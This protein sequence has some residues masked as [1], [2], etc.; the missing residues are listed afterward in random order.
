MYYQVKYFIIEHIYNGDKSM[1]SKDQLSE[2]ILHDY[3]SFNS[4]RAKSDEEIDLTEMDFSNATLEN[5][6]FT[7][8]DL[9]GS[10]FADT[11]LSLVNFTDANLESVDFTRANVVECDFSGALLNGTNFNFAILNYCNFTD[12]DMVGCVLTEA[13]LTDSDLT[14]CEN[15]TASRFDDTTIWP[16]NDML[17]EEFDTSSTRDL[18]ALQDEEDSVNED[19]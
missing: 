16:D 1:Y 11:T 8:C 2:M 17:P 9:S 10:T 5:I 4:F 7:N 12:A 14:A 15:L 6:D 18:S 13:D 3:E 19:Y